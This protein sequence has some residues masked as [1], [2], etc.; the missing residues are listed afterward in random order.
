MT[1]PASVVI[2]GGGQAGLQ[3]AGSL[4]DGGFAGDIT[5]VCA[6]T[7]Y[8]YQRPPLSKAGLETE[9]F[10]PTIRLPKF[11]DDRQIKI[12]LGEHAV[13][14]DRNR[15][16]V[17]T[18][19][20]L[21]F[22]AGH[23][24]LGTGARNR[25][26]P[27]PGEDL[28]GIF[29]LRTVG[30]A[31]SFRKALN[32]AERLV[33]IGA[34]FIGLEVAAVARKRG[35]ATTVID[36]DARPMARAIS[37]QM[38]DYFLDLHTAAGAEILLNR[39]VL[40]IEGTNGDVRAVRLSTGERIA[41]D[42][43]LIGV[44]AAPNVELAVM[45]GLDVDNGIVVDEHLT[46]SDPNISAIGD[47]ASFPASH[48]Q[49]TRLESVQNATDQARSVAAKLLGTPRPYMNVPW[50]WSDQ[51]NTKLQIVGLVP[52]C[53]EVL[54]SGDPREHS[55][56]IF[57]FREKKLVGIE[58]VNRPADH[59]AGRKLLQTRATVSPEQLVAAKFDVKALEADVRSREL[60]AS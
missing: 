25:R 44:G 26:L 9:G 55:F 53:D 11:F 15:L 52:G 50:F 59:M 20:G 41:A 33:I 23:V 56:S 13:G 27:V 7:H 2:V 32:Q 17:S 36:I 46:T 16:S 18:A 21:E 31:E 34:G 58:S 54:V 57:C 51:G 22:Q 6:E 3:A 10:V 43:V 14:I 35:I 48:G 49:R 38:S 4:R 60:E 30:D 39:G 42:L 19:S 5:M 8:P 45:A 47:C 29:Y 24:V 37:Q 40:E 1:L 28:R 12:H